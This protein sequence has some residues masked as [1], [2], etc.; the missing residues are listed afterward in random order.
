MSG[1]HYRREDL[2]SDSEPPFFSGLLQVPC[3]H[4]QREV[5]TAAEKWD[6]GSARS[7]GDM[8]NGRLFK[9]EIDIILLL[10]PPPPPHLHIH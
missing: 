1:T 8:E 5:R 9:S 2:L 7:E 10:P 3:G 4:R 6:F